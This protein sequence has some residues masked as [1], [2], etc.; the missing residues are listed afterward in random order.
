LPGKL[1]YTT[2]GNLPKG[3]FSGLGGIEI[4]KLA[5]SNCC[6]VDLLIDLVSCLQCIDAVGWAAGRA[7]G[8]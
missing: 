8:L 2:W 3:E 6:K 5:F 7:S 4:Y 1:I